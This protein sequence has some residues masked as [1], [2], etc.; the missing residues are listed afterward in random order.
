MSPK[1]FISPVFISHSRTFFK[2]LLVEQAPDHGTGLFPKISQVIKKKTPF[3][4]S[5][6]RNQMFSTIGRGFRNRLYFLRGMALKPRVLDETACP[7]Q[8]AFISK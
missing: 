5:H 2:S 4:R 7:I 6:A 3:H 8:K 1:Q